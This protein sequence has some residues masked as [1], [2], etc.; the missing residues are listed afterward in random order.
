MGL[1]HINI[2]LRNNACNLLQGCW[3]TDLV[4]QACTGEYLINVYPEIINQLQ[5]RYPGWTITTHWYQGA[6]RI[7]LMP[8]STETIKN[9]EVDI[10]PGCYKVWTR[11]CHGANE[12][13]SVAMLQACCE[14]PDHCVNLI[15]PELTVCSGAV[16]H[17]LMDHVVHEAFLADD[18]ER[19]VLMK[20]VMFG[21]KKGKPEVIAELDYRYQEAIDKGDQDLQDRVQAVRNLANQL[22]ECI[23]F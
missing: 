11:V 5:G 21:A 4:I 10:P 14:K 1:A 22:P 19:L 8:P 15:L 17:P 3:R 20:G 16:L 12:E 9:I 23:A 18:P 6:Q 7:M 2:W 13:T